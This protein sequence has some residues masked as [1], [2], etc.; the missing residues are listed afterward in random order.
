MKAAYYTDY[1]A[2]REVLRVGELPDPEPGPGEVRVRIRYSGINPSD[3]NRRVR[4][5]RPAGLSADH[6]AQRRRRRDRQGRRGREASRIGERVWTWNAQ[7]GRALRHRGRVRMLAIGPGRDVAGRR[8][9]RARR[10][11]RRAG[12]DRLLLAVF[13][14]SARRPRRAGHRRRRRCRPLCR[15]VRAARRGAQPRCHS[16]Y[17]RQGTAGCSG[18]RPGHRQLQDRERRRART[19]GHGQARRRP[20]LGSGLRRKSRDHARR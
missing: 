14:R 2:A 18:R 4:Y 12:H 13:G 10:R 7:R 6:S 15:S 5:P 3:C 19:A 1:G 17:R 20:H 8:A 9:A 11:F 16:Q